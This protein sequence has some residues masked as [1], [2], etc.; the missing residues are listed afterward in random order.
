MSD[1]FA[2][3]MPKWGIEM[4]EGVVTDWM[5]KE[6]E[7]FAKG[8]VIM[9]VET[10]KIV[11]DVEAEVGGVLLR[12]IA[13]PGE[14]YAVGTLLGV[15]GSAATAA[16]D[17]ERFI[18]S[19]KSSDGHYQTQV[20][21]DIQGETTI[22]AE[23]VVQGILHANA[24]AKAVAYAQEHRLELTDKMG[25]GR[26]GRIQLQDVQRW[27]REKKPE[28]GPAKDNQVNHSDSRSDVVATPVAQLAASK[29]NVDLATVKG[30]GKGGKIRL[31]DLPRD[32]SK[33]SD[34]SVPF[35]SMRRKIAQRLTQ[36]Y[37]TIPHYYLN[38][39]IRMDEVLAL[40]ESFNND[41]GQNTKASINDFVLKA[42]AQTLKHHPA[43]NVHV[44]DE[45]ITS[46]SDV[47]LSI[48][49]ALE[50]GLVTPVLAKAQQMSMDRLVSESKRLVDG[51]QSGKLNFKDYS[52]GT[53]TVSNLGMF[54][55]DNFTAI[56]NPPQAAILA[57]GAVQS[58]VLAVDGKLRLGQGMT[59]TLG[60]D[61]RVVDGAV[62]GRFL[63][64]LKG[65]L[66]S[67]NDLLA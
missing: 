65:L 43:L 21:Q 64:A 50:D 38:M 55:V 48:A 46:F 45:V 58:K 24:S 3:T 11:N 25:S 10:E 67:P 14:T 36:A 35:S 66:E 28:P 12:A 34:A 1:L 47:N 22:V 53:F 61:H 52:G 15:I 63:S 7:T 62:G 6:G 8:E 26:H 13:E 42:C 18:A 39:D 16:A 49:V 40:R 19:F 54:G 51:A 33:Q 56:I 37:Q 9:A 60:L 17:V 32:D 5:V 59:V 41:R 44:G 4:V 27:V 30:S 31:R 20:T 2:L 57:V 23:D 29:L